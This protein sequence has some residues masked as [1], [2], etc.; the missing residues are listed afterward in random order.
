MNKEIFS[1]EE[2]MMAFELFTD[3]MLKDSIEYDDYLP[4]FREATGATKNSPYE[5]M[6]RGFLGGL[7]IASIDI[8]EQENM[9][10]EVA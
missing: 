3:E 4:G 6:F 10:K 9:P 7:Y 2:A 1:F 8:E 5:F